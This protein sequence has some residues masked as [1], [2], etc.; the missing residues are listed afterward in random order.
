MWSASVTCLIPAVKPSP[1]YSGFLVLSQLE[2]DI[3][4]F[5]SQRQKIDSDVP[6]TGCWETEGLLLWE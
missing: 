1:G 4:P 5:T 6:V 2:V 3:L